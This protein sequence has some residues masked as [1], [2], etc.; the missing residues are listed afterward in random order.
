MTVC[1]R[2]I[3]SF[4]RKK[5]LSSHMILEWS[6]DPP[7]SCPSLYCSNPSTSV[8]RVNILRQIQPNC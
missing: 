2:M 4:V 1:S 3:I 5:A 7:L 8:T 6:C